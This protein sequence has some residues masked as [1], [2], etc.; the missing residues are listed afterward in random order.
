MKELGVADRPLK[1][2]LGGFDEL[3]AFVDATVEAKA[4]AVVFVT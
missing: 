1:E 2:L 3:R 4:G